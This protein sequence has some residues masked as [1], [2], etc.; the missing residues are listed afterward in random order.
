MREVD[1]LR[2]I[3]LHPSFGGRLRIGRVTD[4][5]E[6]HRP[7]G[8]RT[9]DLPWTVGRAD[10]ADMQSLGLIH[11]LSQRHLEQR[12][13][14]G[15]ADFQV[16]GKIVCRARLVDGLSE[17]D[18][19]LGIRQRKRIILLYSSASL[20]SSWQGGRP[21]IPALACHSRRRPTLPISS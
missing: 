14:N 9:N 5:D 13:V 21:R 3:G 7:I 16:F 8:R 18:S 2:Q 10:K 19:K 12:R 1:R 17:P 6:R 15:A 11:H 20:L 4:I